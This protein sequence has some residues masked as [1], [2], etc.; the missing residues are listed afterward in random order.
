[1]AGGETGVAIE[2]PTTNAN[3]SRRPKY[4]SRSLRA[5]YIFHVGYETIIVHTAY[6]GKILSKGCFAE[7]LTE[8]RY[9]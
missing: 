5:P 1:M 9:S 6:S 4:R 7:Q 2:W 3:Q 8:V